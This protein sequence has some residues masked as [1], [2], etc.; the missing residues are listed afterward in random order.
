MQKITLVVALLSAIL[1]AYAYVKYVSQGV[2][3]TGEMFY[4]TNEN[5]DYI[6]EKISHRQHS[7]AANLNNPL[8]NLIAAATESLIINIDAIFTTIY[9]ILNFIMRMTLYSLTFMII[10]IINVVIHLK[11]FLMPVV[12]VVGLYKARMLQY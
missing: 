1:G 5:F 10:F 11:Y 4:L 3:H 6:R 2:S 9:N 8:L 12:I 7:T